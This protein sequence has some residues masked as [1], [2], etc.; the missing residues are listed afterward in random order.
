ML[1]HNDQLGDMFYRL[2]LGYQHNDGF[3]GV[4]GEG[5]LDNGRELYHVTFYGTL[6]P[7]LHDSIDIGFGIVDNTEG[8]E[9]GDH[10]DEYL[11]IQAQRWSAA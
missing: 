4:T 3:P 1:R 6:T 8:L 2:S 5:R 10:P 7:S 11:S 9:D